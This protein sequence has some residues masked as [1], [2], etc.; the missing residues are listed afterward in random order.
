MLQT[1][2]NMSIFKEILPPPFGDLLPLIVGVILGLVI[3]SKIFKKLKDSG[4]WDQLVDKIGGDKYRQIQFQREISSLVK[5]GHL[6]EAAQLYEDR[7]MDNEAINLYLEAEEHTSAG[8]IRP[9]A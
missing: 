7:E 4:R 5:Q 8:E 9:K 6:V 2:I 1:N 3:F